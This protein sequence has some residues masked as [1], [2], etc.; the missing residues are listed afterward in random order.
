MSEIGIDTLARTIYGEA[1]GES[2][3]G[4]TGVACVV[5]NRALAARAYRQVHNKSHPLFGNGTIADACQRPY[6][7]SCWNAGDPN[8]EIIE[9]VTADDKIFAKC[10]DIATQAD[11]G[12]LEDITRGAT[13]YYDGRIDVP[14]WAVGLSPCVSIGHHLFFNNVH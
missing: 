4:M 14:E 7:F 5:V 9:N 2:G 8:C 1:R 13:H 6:Q 12:A 11:A 3:N 10:I